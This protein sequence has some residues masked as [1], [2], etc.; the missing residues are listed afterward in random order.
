MDVI[1]LAVISLGI[2]GAI[3]A[4]VLYVASK[5]FEVYEDPR[6]A[7]VQDILPAANCGGCGYPGCSGFANA[8]VSATT[9]EGLNCPVGG[10][11]VMEQV[12][13]ILGMAVEKTEPK[14][15]VVRCNG[16]CTNR[17]KTNRYDGAP[18]CTIAASLYGGETDCSYGCLGLGDCVKVC[19]FGAIYM[20]TNTRLPVIDEERCTS[21]GACVN[22]CPK[23]LIQ[24][25][26][27]GPKSRRIYVN[28]M[29]KDKGAV[30]G[31]ACS[32]ACIACKKCEKACTFEA[33]KIENNL[34][35]IDDNKCRLCRKCV[36]ECPN[37][38]ILELNFPPRK[39]KIKESEIVS[40]G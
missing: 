7:Q 6:I 32:V 15:A 31:K 28:C 30:A 26:K 20:D 24:L 18:S 9:L 10:Q 12:A 34:A 23:L 16:S 17:Q 1:T 36:T 11:T 2:I 35:Y 40:A 38:S 8:C 5:K 27:K 29:N 3:G 22:A 37:S 21:C 25:R 33:I 39:E 13:G 4:V 14:I 19:T